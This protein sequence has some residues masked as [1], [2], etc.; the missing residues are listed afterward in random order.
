MVKLSKEDPKINIRYPGVENNPKKVRDLRRY[1][2]LND[3]TH[4]K[5][6]KMA[7]KAGFE[8]V[9]FEKRPAPYLLGKICNSIPLI[10]DSLITDVLSVNAGAILRKI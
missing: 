9:S 1:K 4:G 10:K 3:I 8:I 5:F 7:K 6:K 2:D